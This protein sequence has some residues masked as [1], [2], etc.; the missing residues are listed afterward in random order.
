MMPKILIVDDQACIQELIAENLLLEGY[1]VATAGDPGS[2]ERHIQS[3]RPD[4]VLLDL[5]LDGPEGFCLLRDIKRQYP[6]LPVIILTAYDSYREDARLSKADGYVVKSTDFDG[7][8]KK[9]AGA[10]TSRQTYRLKVD[11][12]AHHQKVHVSYCP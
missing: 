6:H 2:A 4:L 11:S 8:K 5:Y 9:I 1:E 10:L 12:E 3:S 7:L